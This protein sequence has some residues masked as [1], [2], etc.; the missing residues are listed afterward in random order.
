MKFTISVD[1]PWDFTGPDGDNVMKGEVIYEISPKE[2]IFRSFK[3]Q[4]F[5]NH[6]GN[7]FLFISRHVGFDLVHNT[8]LG[9]KRYDGTFGAGLLKDS[10]DYKNKTRK[11]L[12]K[13]SIYVF[14]GSFK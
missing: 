6:R 2:L 1:E 9:K 5:D 14:I 12:E 3:K 11:E 4:K 8:I 13:E 7:L 10:V